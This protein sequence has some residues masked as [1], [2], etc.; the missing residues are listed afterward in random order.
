[1]D[2][3]LNFSKDNDPSSNK[4][5][6]IDFNII[7]SFFNRNKKFISSVSI[8]F[9]FLGYLYSFFPKRVWEGQFQIVLN[10]EKKNNRGLNALLPSATSFAFGKVND[11]KTEVGILKSPSVLMPAFEIA[12]GDNNQ[13]SG[14]NYEFSKWKKDN[15]IIELEKNTS[16]LNIFYKDTNKNV[17]LPV[18]E[19]MSSTYQEYSGK[20]KN[21]IDQN[22]ENYLK[23]QIKLF[24][25]K[26][27][28]SL[29]KA[30]EFA[31]DQD[32]I[33][34][35]LNQRKS[36]LK[37]VDLDKVARRTPGFTGA[38]F[39][40]QNINI[41]NVRAS[42]ANEIRKIDLQ[43]K[44][45]AEFNEFEELQYIGSTIPVLNSQEDDDLPNGLQQIEEALIEARSK[46]T[47]EDR[48]IKILLNKRKIAVDSL[49]KRAINY[50]KAK[51][52]ENEAI[53]EAA[54]RPKGVLLKY[55]E[56]IRNSSRDEFTLIELENELR[57]TELGQFRKEAPWELIS[58]PTLSN[59]PVDN[60]RTNI[61]LLSLF[62]GFFV[63]TLYSFYKEKKSE[64][65]FE[66]KDLKLLKGFEFGEIIKLNLQ[67]LDAENTSFIKEFINKKFKEGINLIKLGD[68]EE[69]KIQIIVEKC[70]KN[71]TK[72]EVFKSILDFKNSSN[73]NSNFL[74]LELGSF[75]SL[76][77]NNFKKYLELFDINL[78]GTIIIE[79]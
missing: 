31:I 5:E 50:L 16:I 68:V 43:L 75:T 66:Y 63:S 71:K 4:S 59:E 42:A 19:K 30:Q 37:D 52:L 44:K 34:F 36:F 46:Y 9:I 45:I 64:M 29:R 77:I 28:E 32:L 3:N 20:R 58:K 39:L 74:I 69:N 35:D 73:S 25:E 15:L 11:L 8:I 12:L 57:L 41:E 72:I 26:S 60:T 62:M 7:F 49:K 27:A 78:A 61:I 65:I 6:E 13:L 1:M 40:P 48:A 47:E 53:M 55:K 76:Q 10:T 56:L 23:K 2:S 22:T 33:Y 17:I 79:K 70:T 51:R 24:K 54:S 18:L 14:N 67:L 38:S 21:K